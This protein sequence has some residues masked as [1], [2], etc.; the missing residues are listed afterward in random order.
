MDNRAPDFELELADGG[1]L[2]RDALNVDVT[3]RGSV[4]TRAGYTLARAGQDCHSLWAPIGGAYGLYCDAGTIYRADVGATSAVT[5]TLVA[6]GFG[7]L[8]PVRYAQVNE[9][10]YYSDSIAI[11]SYH[12]KPGPTP[13]W[14]G[15][16]ARQVGDQALTPMPAG[17]CIAHHA[18]RLLVAVGRVLVFSEP[19][20]PNLR[21]LSSGYEMFPGD[22]T[23]VIAVEGGVFV[24]TDAQT[25]FAAGGFPAQTI[26]EVLAYGAPAQQPGYRKDGGAHWMS[27]EGV[28]SCSKAGEFENLQEEHIALSATGAAATLWREADGMTSIVAALSSPSS[29]GAGVGSYAEARIVKKE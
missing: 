28:V 23:S 19:F 8:T 9:A 21:D 29:T 7:M 13:S 26:T 22:I 5:R 4:K 2:L 24:T 17:S 15:T 27:S 12:P 25:F 3:Q 1:H 14:P 16:V 10:V 6:L 11:G 20:M 18:G